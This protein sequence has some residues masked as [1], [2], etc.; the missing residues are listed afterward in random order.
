MKRGDRNRGG[1]GGPGKVSL[2]NQRI[3]KGS[4]DFELKLNIKR[5]KNQMGRDWPESD[6]R[7]D[8]GRGGEGGEPAGLAWA[9]KNWKQQNNKLEGTS[10]IR[11]LL[12]L[13][14]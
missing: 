6:T 2:H 12:P 4:G 11:F 13:L 5:W 7:V 10:E 3:C 9:G 14:N 8:G 1:G